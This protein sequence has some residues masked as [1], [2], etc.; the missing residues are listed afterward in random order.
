LLKIRY[1]NPTG[2]F[3]YG[4][5]SNIDVERRGLVNLVGVN[6]DTGGD[7]NGAGKSS[8]FN[9]LCE[10]LFGENPTGVSGNEVV[11]QV[12]DFGFAGRVEFVSWEGVYYRVTYCRGWKEDYYPVDNDTK[13]AY[14]GTALFLD[15]FDGEGWKDARAD[16]MVAT[17]KTVL[18]ALG[19]TYSRFL[20][21]AY[22]SHR[23]GSRFLRGSNKERVDILAGV[24]GVEEWDR[25]LI[26][27]RNEKNTRQREISETQQRI[28]YDEGAL[29]SMEAQHAQLV[30]ANW[31]DLVAQYTGALVQLDTEVKAKNA[32]VQQK[33]EELQAL[34]EEQHVA[35][36]QTG[37]GTISQEISDLSVR[38]G[39]L[40]NPAFIDSSLPQVDQSYAQAVQDTRSAMDTLLAE[41]R[42]HSGQD[43][44]WSQDECPT[45]GALLSEEKKTAHLQKVAD[46]E[47][48]VE[49]SRQAHEK[50]VYAQQQAQD[51]VS[52]ARDQKYRERL[53][54]ADRLRSQLDALNT[55][56]QESSLEYERLSGRVQ[57]AN[58]AI[59]VLQSEASA[60]SHKILQ[61]E[62]YLREAKA[63]EEEVQSVAQKIEDRKKSVS[64]LKQAIE[65]DLADL[66]VME[67][68]ISNI[69]FVKL[70]RMSVAMSHLSELV[71]RYLSEMG[72]TV[73]VN[74]SSFREKKSGKGAGDVKD[75]LK[76]EIKV[77]VVDGGKNIDPRLY[78]DGETSKI[79]NALIRALHDLATSAGHGCNLVL[80]DEIFSFV[81]ASNSQR[82]AESFKDVV[83]GTTLVTDNSGH[84]SNLMEFNEVWT[85]RKTN[86]MTVLEV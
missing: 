27:C 85:A 53:A 13:A 34:V 40:R 11:N 86:G 30:E 42:V 39:A 41:L 31:P 81:D 16:S 47:K 79:S 48:R 52:K 22:L 25:I 70:H 24:T 54:E 63:K 38:E 5:C 1:I 43:R 18:A 17:R 19:I 33:S 74:L 61:T 14:K 35:Y 9:A 46:L 65:G 37:S 77:E 45:C 58:A 23:T 44:F 55:K 64:E 51:Q 49:E 12:M 29:S 68:L 32:E 28:S 75:L 84:V 62:G 50:A 26:N 78:S 69:P 60:L 15:R 82:L 83:A 8:L 6:D 56:L 80:L 21:I 36:E 66:S 20:S 76:S 10:I 7:S 59:R 4:R 72:D 71:N 73:R 3:S 2:M 67:W 57:E